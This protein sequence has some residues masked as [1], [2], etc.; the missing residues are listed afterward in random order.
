M[1]S[2]LTGKNVDKYLKYYSLTGIG[3][4]IFVFLVFFVR[5]D[6]SF[7]SIVSMSW[8]RVGHCIPIK[9]FIQICKHCVKF[10]CVSIHNFI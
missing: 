5:I 7:V 3:C 9:K 6:D 4:T 2:I 10:N 1:G 8:R